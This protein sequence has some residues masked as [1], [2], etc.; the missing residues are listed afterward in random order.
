MKFMYK[1]NIVFFGQMS[2][3]IDL[4]MIVIE[5]LLFVQ[6]GHNIKSKFSRYYIE[7]IYC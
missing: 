4:E 3:K 7:D 2:N 5:L 1:R 6:I